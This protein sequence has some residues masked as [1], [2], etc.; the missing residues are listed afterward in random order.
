[1][2]PRHAATWL[3]ESLMGVNTR[4]GTKCP[5]SNTCSRLLQRYFLALHLR[6]QDRAESGSWRLRAS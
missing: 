5:G 3:E 4:V 6:W 1:M 2:N